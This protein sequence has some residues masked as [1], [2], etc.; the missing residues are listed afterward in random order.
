MGTGR[1]NNQGDQQPNCS[2]SQPSTASRRSLRAG[3][4]IPAPMALVRNYL[5]VFFGSRE[6]ASSTPSSLSPVVRRRSS[7]GMVANR[8]RSGFDSGV[9]ASITTTISTFLCTSIPAT[10]SAIATSRRGSG[11]MRA[12]RHHTPSR[13]TNHP[14]GTGWRDT[15]WFKHTRQRPQPIQSRPGLRRSTPIRP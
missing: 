1:K 7:L 9:R 12:Q 10:V 5:T 14:S 6:D 4:I 11:R 8:R 2:H 13:A 15:D 3:L